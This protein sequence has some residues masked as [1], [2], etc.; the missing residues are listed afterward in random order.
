MALKMKLIANVAPVTAPVAVLEPQKV[1]VQPEPSETETLTAEY[2]ELYKK[3]EY[4][5]VKDLLKRMDTI[6]KQLQTVANETMDGLKPAV[7]S[8]PQG[9][10]EFSERKREAEVID[11]LALI[12]ELL[13]KF[14]PEVTESV[15]DIAITPLRKLL[16]EFELKKHLTYEPGSRTLVSVRPV[17]MIP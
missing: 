11:A 8:C 17:G 9:E 1:F 3:F 5:E 13:K 6:R 7:F 12:H 10:M 4:F 16:S 2:I 14:G 15:V